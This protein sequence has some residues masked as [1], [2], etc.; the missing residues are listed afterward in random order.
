MHSRRRTETRWRYQS[1]WFLLEAFWCWRQS[2]YW[3]SISLYESLNASNRIAENM[4]LKRVGTRTLPCLTP[5]VTGKATELFP[6]SCTLACMPSWN[7]LTMAMNFS[8][9][10]YFAIILQRP[11][12]LTMS[13]TLVRSTLV[14]STS[15]FCFWQFSWT[16]LLQ[17]HS[18]VSHYTMWPPPMIDF[19][20]GWL[21][22]YPNST[23]VTHHL[24]TPL[25]SNKKN[26]HV[27]SMPSILHC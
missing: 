22:I 3:M 1:S 13:N 2:R 16:H 23:L 15:V 11:S 18:P 27:Y 14:E 26:N 25:Y 10:P 8:G 5:F 7:C 6:L 21:Q 4:I 9:Q 12:L 20:A 17:S 24:C 19:R